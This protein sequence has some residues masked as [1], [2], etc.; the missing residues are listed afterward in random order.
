MECDEDGTCVDPAISRF[1]CYFD[2][3]TSKMVCG[4][5]LVKKEKT[6]EK[7]KA[8]NAIISP[9]LEIS[10]VDSKGFF[11]MTFSQKMNF[12]SLINET[13]GTSESA[14]NKEAGTNSTDFSKY[15]LSSKHIKIAILVN[16]DQD[17]SKL[18]LDWVVADIKDKQI[19][20]QVLFKNPTF[21][22]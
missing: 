15:L 12:S 8:K 7:N 11:T 17:S 2:D 16:P 6:S 19:K 9:T 14:G 22:S 3:E 18:K 5:D 1:S 21:I 10:E 20:I 4:V 13:Y